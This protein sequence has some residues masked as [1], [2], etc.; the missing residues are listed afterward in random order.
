M[1]FSRIDAD[2]PQPASRGRCHLYV[3]P[4]P[5]E[6]HCKVG[7]SRDPLARAQSMHRRWF[8]FFDLEGGYVVETETV[9]DARDLELELRRL[10]VEHNAPAPLTVRREAAGH[11]EWYRGAQTL[12]DDAVDTLRA[13]G[14]TVHA[15]LRTWMGPAL[16]ERVD[17]LY[18]WSLPRLSVDEL[19]G[20]AGATPAQQQVRDALDAYAALDVDLQPHLPPEVWGWYR[21]RVEW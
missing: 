18:A 1:T 15:P 8:E 2:D 21:G 11:T 19:D 12:L 16:L 6:D 13:R 14:H 3:L 5:W 9:R 4:R 7:F 10:L 17:G 20:I